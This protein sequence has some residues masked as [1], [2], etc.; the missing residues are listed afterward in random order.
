MAIWLVLQFLPLV[1]VAT[2][3]RQELADWTHYSGAEGNPDGSINLLLFGMAAS[4]LLS[5]TAA[6]WRTGG[7]TC[8]SCPSVSPGNARAWWTALILTG[9]GLGSSWVASNWS[10]DLSW[11]GWPYAT[12]LRSK[13]RLQPTSMYSLAFRPDPRLS[14]AR[15]TARGGY[16]SLSA[17]SRSM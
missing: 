6:D 4:T 3:G 17:S 5:L 15:A 7:P 2:R 10:Q 14:F 9:P 1:Y 16:S 12:G 8:A 13:R 11:P